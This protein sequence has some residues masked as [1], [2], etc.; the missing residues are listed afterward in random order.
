MAYLKPPL[1]QRRTLNSRAAI[2][3]SSQTRTVPVIP[4]EHDG[5]RYL[6]SAR[7]EAGWVLNLRAA[8]NTGELKGERFQATELPVEERGPIIEKYRQTAGKMV[9]GYWKKLPDPV[10]HPVFRLDPA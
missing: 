7:G 9:D 1:F 10:D 2:R 6:V 5:A 8:G 3:R 4:V